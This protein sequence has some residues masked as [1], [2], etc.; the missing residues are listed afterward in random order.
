MKT[1]DKHQLLIKLEEKLQE[2]DSAR[3]QVDQA[4]GSSNDLTLATSMLA[5]EVKKIADHVEG[6]FHDAISEDQKGNDNERAN[7]RKITAELKDNL[8]EA[9]NRIASKSIKS[10]ETQEDLNVKTIDSMQLC[11]KEIQSYLDRLLE[12]NIDQELKDIYSQ[13]SQIERYQEKTYNSVIIVMLIVAVLLGFSV[14]GL[15]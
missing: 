7:F 10:L 4:I 14:V 1:D 3:E 15:S 12:I 6:R 9:V 11:I 8:E 13:I 2:L 5:K